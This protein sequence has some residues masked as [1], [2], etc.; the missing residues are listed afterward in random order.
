V[1]NVVACNSLK[2]SGKIKFGTLLVYREEH[3]FF[4]GGG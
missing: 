2:E 3:F 4:G 1:T